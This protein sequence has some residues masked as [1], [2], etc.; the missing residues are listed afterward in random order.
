[1][2]TLCSKRRMGEENGVVAHWVNAVRKLMADAATSD[3]TARHSADKDLILDAHLWGEA[4]V[5][6]EMDAR[7]AACD[8]AKRRFNAFNQLAC[9]WYAR[10]YRFYLHPTCSDAPKGIANRV[11]G[12]KWVVEQADDAYIAAFRPHNDAADKWW[13]LG[14]HKALLDEARREME[15]EEQQRQQPPAEPSTRPSPRPSTTPSA[16]PVR[17]PIPGLGPSPVTQGVT[18]RARCTVEL[19]K[20]LAKLLAEPATKTMSTPRDDITK[21]VLC[22]FHN[23]RPMRAWERDETG[24]PALT[25]LEGDTHAMQLEMSARGLDGL[26]GGLDVDNRPALERIGLT[27]LNGGG[28]NSIWVA[29]QGCEGLDALFPA[30]VVEPFHKRQLVLRIPHC[31]CEQR[32][33]E[34]K[35]RALWLTLDEA[36]GEATNMLFTAMSGCGPRVAA[37]AFARR[38]EFDPEHPS[39]GVPTVVYK[40]YAWLERATTT[41]DERFAADRGASAPRLALSSRPYFDALLVAIWRISN[42]GFVHCDATLRNFVDFYKH[43]LF[44][45]TSCNAFAVKVIDVD[46]AAFRRLHPASTTDWRYL[47]LYNLLTVLVFLKLKLERSWDASVYWSR[48]QPV[49]QQLISELPETRTVASIAMW[50]GTF[51]ENE[52]F[53]SMT[54]GKFAGGTPEA[55]AHAAVRYMKHY[56]LMQPIAEARKIYIG[57]LRREPPDP[58]RLRDAKAWYDNSYRTSVA[59]ARAFFMKE[60]CGNAAPKRFVQ[61]AYEFLETPH[62]AL[63]KRYANLLPPTNEHRPDDTNNYLLGL[64][65]RRG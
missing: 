44:H 55:A 9:G 16:A 63:E 10:G 41:V 42:E 20:L 13:K 21:H 12:I 53:P 24:M 18:K 45:S 28:Y 4:M 5:R 56:L 29:G 33:G 46:A 47:F 48:V 2:P 25:F 62:N 3:G 19:P 11:C 14:L 38:I 34:H 51:D 32:E 27:H 26:F 58:N 6:A 1:M 39:E 52:E 64:P 30:V 15:A 50:R 7:T 36:V 35:P 8:P 60:Y 59:P 57:A 61:V 40:L 65:T 49:C 31:D 17:R 23:L 22:A 54:E 37:L 43:D